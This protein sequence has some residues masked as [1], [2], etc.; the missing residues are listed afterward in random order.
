MRGDGRLNTTYMEYYNIFALLT[1][2]EG[3]IFSEFAMI[4][5]KRCFRN[6]LFTAWFP[7]QGW[8]RFEA[9]EERCFF[10]SKWSFQPLRKFQRCTKEQELEG[11][12]KYFLFSPLFGGRFPFWLIFFKWNETTNQRSVSCFEKSFS[13]CKYIYKIIYIYIDSHPS[14]FKGGGNFAEYRWILNPGHPRLRW[15]ATICDCLSGLLGLGFSLVPK[16]MVGDDWVK[17]HL[18]LN[19]RE[20]GGTLGTVP[21]I[22]NPIYTLYSGLRLPVC[23]NAH[24]LRRSHSHPFHHQVLGHRSEESSR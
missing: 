12:F 4:C 6:A 13:D 8:G 14:L 11:G 19:H 2:S 9:M 17:K 24:A 21:L 23:G 7:S 1:F 3:R 16:E 15:V 20:H 10:F 18:W 22:I 5:G